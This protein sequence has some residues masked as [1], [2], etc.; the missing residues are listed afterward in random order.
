MPSGSEPDV[1]LIPL[2]N[3]PAVPAPALKLAWELEERGC[4]FELEGE[5]LIIS[6]RRLLTD[7]DREAIKA[8]KPDLVRI[9]AYVDR[10][11]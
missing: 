6:P 7:A 3:G 11:Q 2:K 4:R 8:W 1:E 10:L 5:T 9:I